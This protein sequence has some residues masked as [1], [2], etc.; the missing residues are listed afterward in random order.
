MKVLARLR[1]HQPFAD[2]EGLLQRT[3]D[4]L[5]Q[6]YC[7]VDCYMDDEKGPVFDMPEIVMYFASTVDQP[8]LD[9]AQIV[10]AAMPEHH[11]SWAR[12]PVT[13]LVAKCNEIKLNGR[14]D[15]DTDAALTRHVCSAMTASICCGMEPDKELL[16]EL[17]F[18][19]EDGH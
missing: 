2:D 9:A 8:S 18:L 11:A 15:K 13:A 6:M 19:I 4:I 5:T 3:L 16:R 10:I 7:V 14:S 17:F 1:Q 12:S